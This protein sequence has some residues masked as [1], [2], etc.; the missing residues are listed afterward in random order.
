MLVGG[1]EWVVVAAAD[2]QLQCC[3]HHSARTKRAEL[4][5]D[6]PN[7]IILNN[8]GRERPTSTPNEASMCP[9]ELMAPVL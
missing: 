7:Y 8:R 9:E 4:S 1:S 6:L 2:K 3:G 5:G